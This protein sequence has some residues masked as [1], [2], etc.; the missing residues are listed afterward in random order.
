MRDGGTAHRTNFDAPSPTP[1]FPHYSRFV[2]HFPRLNTTAPATASVENA[3]V[4]AT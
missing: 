3:I 4:I 1:P 2:F